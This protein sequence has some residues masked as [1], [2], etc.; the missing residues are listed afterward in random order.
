MRKGSNKGT[1]KH[2]IRNTITKLLNMYIKLK[3]EGVSTWEQWCK[4]TDIAGGI[5]A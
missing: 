2:E 3:V 1:E 5:S 4:E